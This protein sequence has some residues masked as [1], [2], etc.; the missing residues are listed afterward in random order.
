MWKTVS[1]QTFFAGADRVFFPV[2]STSHFT[3]K[4]AISTS[5]QRILE[6]AKINDE[7]K[8]IRNNVIQSNPNVRTENS[9][10]LRRTEW[11]ELFLD[12]DIKTLVDYTSATIRDV[13]EQ[14]YSLILSI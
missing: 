1:V 4:S 3:S 6:A 14:A 9:P 10:W 13:M 7:N 5:L 11:R 12:K 2:Q 8:P